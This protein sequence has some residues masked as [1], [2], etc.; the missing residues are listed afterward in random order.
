MKVCHRILLVS[1]LVVLGG[2]GT[3]TDP[4][5][6]APEVFVETA[7]ADAEAAAV[8]GQE[9]V[10]AAVREL[11]DFAV[12]E[13]FPEALLDPERQDVSREDLAPPAVLDRLTPE[14]AQGFQALVD[15]ALGGDARAQDEVRT[16]RY[17]G[18]DAAWTLPEQ[19]PVVRS[20]RI[21]DVGVE[22]DSTGG[23]G[24]ELLVVSFDHDATMAFGFDD[25]P[26]RLEVEKEMTYVLAPVPADEGTSW[27]IASF[28][29]EFEASAGG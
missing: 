28:E 26:L 8:F 24:Q 7:A 6:V 29:G 17:Y 9:W 15:A 23:P 27:L 3:V 11:A 2:C 21:T 1:S 22:V 19:D 14:A 5:E 20:Q 18:V 12:A 4:A 10:D 25:E 13:A 16:L